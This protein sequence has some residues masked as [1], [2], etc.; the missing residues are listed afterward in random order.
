MDFPILII[1]LSP[2]FSGVIFVMSFLDEI[3]VS[4]QKSPTWDAAYYGVT[5]GAILFAYV[6]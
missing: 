5:S 3:H 2:R 4:K 1:W 6:P